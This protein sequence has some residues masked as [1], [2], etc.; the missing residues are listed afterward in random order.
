MSGGMASLSTLPGFSL[1]S[2]VCQKIVKRAC[3]TNN[4]EHAMKLQH[5]ALFM[6]IVEQILGESGCL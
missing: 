6:T 1:K 3:E 4:L 5:I 2:F